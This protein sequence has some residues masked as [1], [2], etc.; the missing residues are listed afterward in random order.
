[1]PQPMPTLNETPTVTPDQFGHDHWSLLGYLETLMADT[2]TPGTG[3]IDHDR[4]RTNPR[5]HPLLWGAR[6]SIGKRADSADAWN[7]AW[8]SRIANGEKMSEHD[9]WDCLNDLEAAGWV[10]VRSL[11]N[12]LFVLTPEGDRV[13]SVLRAHKRAGGTFKTFSYASA[14]QQP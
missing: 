12:G 8:G 5:R 14:P 6:A 3:Q 1:M 10:D 9:D 11:V 13:A 7:P 2:N 4:M